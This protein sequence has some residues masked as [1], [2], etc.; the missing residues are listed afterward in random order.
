MS[1]L[2]TLPPR[3][4]KGGPDDAPACAAIEAECARQFR[5]S[6][7]P[8]VAD[9]PAALAAAHVAAAER[10]ELFVIEPGETAPEAQGGIAGF[11][12]L[13]AAPPCLHVAE[14]DV[15]PRFQRRGLARALLAHAEGLARARGFAHLCLTTFTD[16]AWNAPAYARMGFRPIPADE[17]PE[18]CRADAMRLAAL[19]F[20]P[21]RRVAMRRPV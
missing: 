8:Q 5:A 2:G 12:W 15:A 20:D 19:G 3:I 17:I 11:A 6:P 7:H 16:V 13:I 21:A 18:I 4:R 14:I 9:R 1:G 10:G